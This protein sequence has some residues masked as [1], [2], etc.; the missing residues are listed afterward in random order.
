MEKDELVINKWGSLK[1]NVKDVYN[2]K[3]LNEKT[4]TIVTINENEKDVY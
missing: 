1:A 3:A 2:V 4:Q